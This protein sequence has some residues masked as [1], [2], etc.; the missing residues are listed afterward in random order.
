MRP[1]TTEPEPLTALLDR[2]SAHYR[3]IDHLPEGRT[4]AASR[5]RG[6]PLGA[7]AK[8][9]VLRLKTGKTRRYVLVVV[10]GDRRVD[11][12]AVRDLYGS[13][14]AAVAP[15]DV[16]ERL[17]GCV[18][19]AIPPFTFHPE[20]DLVVDHG[21]TGHDEI[22]FNAGVLDRSLALRTEDYLRVSRPRVG[23]VAASTGD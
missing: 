19:G 15:A 14:N 2:E 17:T 6:H 8:C 20:L 13:R 3:I 21:L 16:A 10:P 23:A 9:L 11:I 1:T 18:S 4:E 5:L 7:A 22:Y 12:A